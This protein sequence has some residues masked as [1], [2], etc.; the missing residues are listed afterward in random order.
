MGFHS[1]AAAVFLANVL[2]VAFVWGCF[3]FH[4]HD[5]KAPW[6]A[7]AATLMPLAYMVI[8]LLLTEGLPPQ[9]DAIALR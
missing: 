1:V 4:K 2:A 6:L 7:Y 3:Q 9:F 8:G 5:Y